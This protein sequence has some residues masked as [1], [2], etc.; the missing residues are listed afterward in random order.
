MCDLHTDGF[1]C[2]AP[3]HGLFSPVHASRRSQM[4]GE[5]ELVPDDART[6]SARTGYSRDPSSSNAMSLADALCKQLRYREAAELYSEAIPSLGRA[7]LRRLA[8]CHLKT[9]RLDEAES[10]FRRC[11]ELGGDRL[12]IAYRLGLTAYYSGRYDD[13]EKYFEECIPLSE[14]NGDMYVAA[15]Y[16]YALSLLGAGRDVAPAAATFKTDVK[17]GHHYG[18]LAACR[19]FAGEL[20]A[21][22]LA[23]QAAK[24]DEMTRVIML[25]ALSRVAKRNGD[26][27]A[28]ALL[29]AVLAEDTYWGCFAWMAA[30]YDAR[31][32]ARTS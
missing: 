4:D 11:G 23:A 14:N 25:Y 22:E 5:T 19:M 18:Y 2:A 1:S 6:A 27:A 16:W 31:R 15:V 8:L 7:A 21:D 3:F 20:S 9:G 29:R 12:D 26:P 28:P 13:A 30:R 10:E 24:A 17:I 32:D